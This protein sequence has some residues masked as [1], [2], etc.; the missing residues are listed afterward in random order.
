MAYYVISDLHG[1]YQIFKELIYKINLTA[2]DSLF[3]IGDAIDRGADGIKILMD[4]MRMPNSK[5]LIGNHEA[6]MLMS[7]NPSGELNLTGNK[8]ELWLYSNG[9]NVTWEK[10]KKLSFGDRIRLLKWLKGCSLSTHIEVDGNPLLLTHS[11]FDERYIDVPYSDIPED[12]IWQLVWESPFRWDTYV[13]LEEYYKRKET[14][15]IGH[16]PVQ[17]IRR[18]YL[19]SSYRDKN[20]IVIDGGC[21]MSGSDKAGGI[22]LRLDDMSEAVVAFEDVQKEARI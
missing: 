6:M 3:V 12:I 18:E 1:Q 20:L 10:Y 22:C 19:L 14:V 11:F 5:L 4:L 2:R 16:V 7:V 21:A 9:G 15:V 8:A 13:P 17:R